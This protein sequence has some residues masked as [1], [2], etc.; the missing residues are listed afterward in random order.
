MARHVPTFFEDLF[1]R[2]TPCPYT[3]PV[4][5]HNDR[6][7]MNGVGKCRDVACHV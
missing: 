2:G 3:R 5:N 1:R 6:P 4:V 7:V